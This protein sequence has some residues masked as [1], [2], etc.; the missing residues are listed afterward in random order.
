[1][2]RHLHRGNVERLRFTKYPSVDLVKCR[3][4]FAQCSGGK[5]L[6]SKTDRAICMCHKLQRRCST[7]PCAEGRACR[8]RC[9]C[10]RSKLR[11]QQHTSKA[12]T[13]QRRLNGSTTRLR[14]TDSGASSQVLCY[15]LVL[16]TLQACLH[17]V[18]NA[19][20]TCR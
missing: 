18:S 12:S 17:H 4:H 11:V 15:L 13:S 19:T 7:M 6:V 3:T 16:P 14:S 20:L 8:V 5:Y 10:R 2:D 1:M 9:G